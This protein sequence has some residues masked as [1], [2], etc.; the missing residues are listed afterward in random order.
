MLES[1]GA[2]GKARWIRFKLI[3]IEHMPEFSAVVGT[4]LEWIKGYLVIYKIELMEELGRRPG[5]E[6]ERFPDRLDAYLAR[7]K[8]GEI[9]KER[10]RRDYREFK[11]FYFDH[12]DDAKRQASFE[13]ALR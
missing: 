2:L 3:G 11:D 6:F 8:S 4:P 13:A 1:P 9:G 10:V 5:I 12:N 7:V